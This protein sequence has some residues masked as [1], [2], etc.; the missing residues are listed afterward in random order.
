MCRGK[1]EGVDLALGNEGSKSSFNT[2]FACAL[3]AG[4]LL[5]MIYG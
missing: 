3:Q 4:L 2:L 1:G 5:V